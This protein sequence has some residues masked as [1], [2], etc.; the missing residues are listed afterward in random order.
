MT[1]STVSEYFNHRNGLH[2]S[3]DIS[4]FWRS[5][6]FQ[7]ISLHFVKV[8]LDSRLQGFILPDG[9][10][11]EGGACELTWHYHLCD[12]T[13]QSSGERQLTPTVKTSGLTR[14]P[15]GRGE[16]GGT[17]CSNWGVVV[18][19]WGAVASEGCVRLRLTSSSPF[20]DSGFL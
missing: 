7:P 20:L 6:F 19:R 2:L 11:A 3:A 5:Q 18:S 4:S 8:T 13:L 9:C 14:R 1:S 15:K 12:I 10:Q 17:W 16:L